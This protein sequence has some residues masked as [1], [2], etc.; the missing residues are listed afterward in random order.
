MKIVC[1]H[2]FFLFEE[3]EVGQISQFMSWS[4]LSIVPR[5]TQYTFEALAEAPDFSLVGLDLLGV[6]ATAT[7]EGQPWEIF[8]AN[9]LIYNFITGLI[10]PIESITQSVS[11]K[12]S[13]NYF[14]S[15]GLILPGSVTADG[16]RVK[17]YSAWF[18]R[19][20]L[21]F[22]YSEVTYV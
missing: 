13:G 11:V 22:Y 17:D 20:N 5:G 3:T 21:R 16:D 18:S 15:N 9:G 7:I 6:P 4:G 10:V 8:E 2:G 14:I 12:Q 1:R 19:S